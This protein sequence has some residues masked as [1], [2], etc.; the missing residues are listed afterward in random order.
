MERL[1][2]LMARLRQDCPWDRAQTFETIAPCTIEEAYE[3][4]DAIEREDF[5]ALRDELGDLLFQVVF[6]AH[7][8]DEKG[9]FDIEGVVDS[10]LDKMIRRHPHVFEPSADG[11]ERA[12]WERIKAK[13]RPH[14]KSAL[15]GLPG[16]LPP[17][18]KAAKLQRRAAAVGFD[19][20]DVEGVFGKLDEE[21]AELREALDAKEGKGRAESE[22]G[23]ILFTCVNLARRLGLD[24]DRALAG[25]N[26]RFEQRFRTMERLTTGRG[27]QLEER[28][29]A[30]LDALWEQA[31]E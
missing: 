18:A 30:E 19:W 10:V 15:D 2:G 6:H 24:C 5:D 14:G 4:A 9:R 26:R 3:V 22:L 27:R 13:E 16:A 23:D 12:D 11:A 25:A 17:L 21:V 20:P 7:L 29:A 31:K 28:T 8:A 1:L